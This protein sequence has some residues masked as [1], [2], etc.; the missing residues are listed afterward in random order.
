MLCALD[1]VQSRQHGGASIALAGCSTVWHASVSAVSTFHSIE[2]KIG[3]D[4]FLKPPG[5]VKQ[6]SRSIWDTVGMDVH[7]M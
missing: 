3:Q 2:L 7:V 6:G 1:A 5:Y 4:L